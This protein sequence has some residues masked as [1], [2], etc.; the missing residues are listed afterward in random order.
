[1]K[2]LHKTCLFFALASSTSALTHAASLNV[3]INNDALRGQYNFSRED[4]GLGLSAAA[5]VTDDNGEIY[6][7]TVRTQGRLRSQQFIRG[8]FGGRLYHGSPEGPDSFQALGLGGFV[9]VTVPQLTDITVGVDLYY[10]PS[11]AITDDLDNLKELTFKVAYQL[12]DNANVYA[13]LRFLEIEQ[14]DFDYEFDDNAHIG[15]TLQF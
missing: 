12:F 11:I 7:F 3:D 5:M 2:T 6:S 13:G 8:G 15:F 1:M 14:G 9:D 10:A 4:A